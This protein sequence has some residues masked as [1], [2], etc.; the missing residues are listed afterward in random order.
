M[1]R[2]FF[3]NILDFQLRIRNQ[4]S[5]E[6]HEK[7][8]FSFFIHCSIFLSNTTNQTSSVKVLCVRFLV[9][10]HHFV[11][12][13]MI[14]LHWKRGRSKTPENEIAKVFLCIQTFS[15]SNVCILSWV[16]MSG[17]LKRTLLLGFHL[18]WEL[19]FAKNDKSFNDCLFSSFLHLFYSQYYQLISF[20]QCF[21]GNISF[22]RAASSI[23]C[24]FIWTL[25]PSF[26]KL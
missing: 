6:S 1:S 10:E 16:Y 11:L 21:N 18:E 17:L 3:N 22:L 19:P 23:V 13:S 8:I 2:K 4:T 25:C 9:V 5:R 26:W 15:K 20:H 14:F 24:F 7:Q 12:K